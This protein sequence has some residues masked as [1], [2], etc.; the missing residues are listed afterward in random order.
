MVTSPSWD[1]GGVSNVG[2]VTWGSG[3]SGI[4]GTV[5]AT[6]SLVG[7]TANDNVGGNGIVALN[8]GNY[9][10]RNPFWDNS[11]V[12]DAGAVTWCNG[13]TGRA[14]AVSSANSL[15][16]SIA[17]D[18]VGGNS[19]A[20]LNNG[21]YVV[22]SPNW[23]NGAASNAG[24]VTWGSGTAGVSGVVSSANSLVGTATGDQVGNGGIT[25]LTNGNYVV[26]A[27]SWDNGAITNAGAVTWCNGTTG[28]T[29][30]ISSANSL[31]GSIASDQV[32]SDVTALVNGNYVVRSTNWDNGAVVNAGAVTW[33]D[34]TSGRTGAVSSANSL[35]GST[36]NDQVGTSGI[37]ALSNGNYVVHSLN[38]DNG[39]A[40]NA[41]AITLGSGTAGISGAV[42]AV[43][44]LVG[45]T[46]SDQIGNGGITA[47]AN[48]NYLVRSLSWDN[49]AVTEAGAASFGFGS[50]SLSGPI[51]GCNSVLGSAVNQGPSMSLF[52]NPVYN[53]LLVALP[54]INTVAIFT[55]GGQALPAAGS[56]SAS[57]TLSSY[58]PTPLVNYTTCQ[59]VAQLQ[60]TGA[61][62][63]QGSVTGTVWVQATVPNVNGVPYV[64]RHYDITPTANAASA[65]ATVTL[66]FTLAEFN[67]FNTLAAVDLPAAP[68]DVAGIAALRIE[69]RSGTSTNGTGLPA[70][71]SGTIET[72]D[73]D[74][75]RIVWNALLNRWEVS[76]AVAG[77][78]GFFVKTSPVT[79]PLQLI[80]FQGRRRS[81]VSHLEWRT[82]SEANTSYFVVERSLDG[83]S[84][85]TAGQVAAIGNGSA[86]YRFADMFAFTGMCHYRLKMID[87]DGSFRYSPFVQLREDG[88]EVHLYP[89][90]ASAIQ[91]TVSLQ[92][93]G[94]LQQWA[95]LV[96]VTGRTL[97]RYYITAPVQALDIRGLAAGTYYLQLFGNTPQKLVVER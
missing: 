32:G 39:A 13:T 24:A 37:I 23:D 22:S 21:N 7:S 90:P 56:V 86:H 84:F 16:G 45:T 96:D 4:V 80:H 2:A 28:G 88:F 60:P 42:S 74:D 11:G 20:A 82:E 94:G 35:V 49:G 59:A 33:C 69:K 53:C 95:W 70:T 38:W 31:V 79:L 12:L 26:R 71:Y 61:A 93:K 44:S 36:A 43:N 18:N 65:S 40:T 72:I 76:F 64:Q 10:I 75:S 58:S 34:G 27:I 14:G 15:V 5:S 81:G 52:Y 8:N 19:V 62:P 54:S 77:F 92:T 78:S 6:N 48:G 67:A 46:L 57:A 47:V 29:G 25:I 87:L 66:Y 30:V 51:S 89:N 73:P 97:R 17:N 55:P 9:V 50:A 1:N 91:G 41:G 85:A 63:V 68:S 83:N 3:S